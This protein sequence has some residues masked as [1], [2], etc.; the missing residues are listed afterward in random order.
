MLA[1]LCRKRTGG[2]R[3]QRF[4]FVGADV[5]RRFP[6]SNLKFQVSNRSQPPH[7]G[8][9]NNCYLWAVRIPSIVRAPAPW[10]PQT[11]VAH[12]YFR[13]VV[14]PPLPASRKVLFPSLQLAVVQPPLDA[15]SKEPF[16]GPSEKLASRMTKR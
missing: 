7:V 11:C 10:R 13:S 4:T 5:R 6:I 9:Y 16:G 3:K 12:R 15:N 14:S 1:N 8:S 2:N